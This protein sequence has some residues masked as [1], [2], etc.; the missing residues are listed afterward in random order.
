MEMAITG[1]PIPAEEAARIG[2]VNRLADP[3]GAV[4]AALRLAERIAKNAPLA[5]AASKELVKA[6]QGRTEDE[7]WE[8]QQQHATAVFTSADAQEGAR[9]FAEKRPPQWSGT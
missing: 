8:L 4:D 9:A 3:G 6:S 7:L 1:D 5:V 2:L